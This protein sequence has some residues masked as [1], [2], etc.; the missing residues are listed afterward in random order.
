MLVHYSGTVR[1]LHAR[2]SDVLLPSFSPVDLLSPNDSQ[3]CS[4]HQVA[5]P[6]RRHCPCSLR[7]YILAEKSAQISGRFLVP[8]R[9]R[10]GRHV[11]V[12]VGAIFC[13]YSGSRLT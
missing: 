6:H 11:Q 3:A 4:G 5:T 2:S 8:F 7:P 10:L 12:F 1:P 13:K 9:Q